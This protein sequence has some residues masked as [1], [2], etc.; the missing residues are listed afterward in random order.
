MGDEVGLGVGDAVGLGAGVGI[1]TVPVL[2]A[3][4]SDPP[5]AVSSRVSKAVEVSDRVRR[6]RV[7]V[8]LAVI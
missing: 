8:L 1:V 7:V 2:L 5:Q 3:L 4:E 6:W